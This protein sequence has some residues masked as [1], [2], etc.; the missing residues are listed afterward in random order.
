MTAERLEQ[1]ESER[2]GQAAFDEFWNI[3][4]AMLPESV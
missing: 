3:S 1:A 4:N 2:S